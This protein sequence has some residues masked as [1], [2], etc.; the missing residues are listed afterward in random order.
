MQQTDTG[1]KWIDNKKLS[2]LKGITMLLIEKDDSINLK[3]IKTSYS[4]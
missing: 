2:G 3:P 1:L 4:S